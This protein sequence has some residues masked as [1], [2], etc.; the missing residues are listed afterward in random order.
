MKGSPARRAG[1][2]SPERFGASAGGLLNE[3]LDISRLEAGL[4]DPQLRIVSLQE[5]FDALERELEPLAEEKG[6]NWASSQRAS[7]LRVIATC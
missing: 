7:R 3:L 6:S 4:L 1:M 5:V 2:G